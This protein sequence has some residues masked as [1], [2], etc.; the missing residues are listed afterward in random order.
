LLWPLNAPN[1]QPGVGLRDEPVIVLH[2][3]ED[4][5]RQ[6]FPGFRRGLP[7]LRMRTRNPMD[8]LRGPRTIVVPDVLGDDP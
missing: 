2:A 1:A 8:R 5:E 4:G 6:Y 7:Q 3:A